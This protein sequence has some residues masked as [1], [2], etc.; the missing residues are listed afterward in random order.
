MYAI[1]SYYGILDMGDGVALLEF[2]AKLN[3]I[4]ADMVAMA[5]TALARLDSDFDALVI[6]N[7]G[8]DFC[9]G[10]N[11]ATV[12]IAAAQGMWD[13]INVI[14]SYSIHYTKL[15]DWM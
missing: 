3:A 1:R 13:E 8:Q 14:T 7:N 10:A 5:N 2:H 12:G 15:Y 11:I 4:D 6:G 9:V